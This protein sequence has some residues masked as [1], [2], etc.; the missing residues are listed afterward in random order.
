MFNPFSYRT[1]SF[2]DSSTHQS[3]TSLGPPLTTVGYFGSSPSQSSPRTSGWCR[4]PRLHCSGL[5]LRTWTVDPPGTPGELSLKAPRDPR[6]LYLRPMNWYLYSCHRST[7]LLQPSKDQKI[8]FFRILQYL[9]VQ[10]ISF[11]LLMF[12]SNFFLYLYWVLG[13]W[14]FSFLI[15][16]TSSYWNFIKLNCTFDDQEQQGSDLNP[17]IFDQKRTV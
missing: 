15:K 3:L 2:Y 13:W 5:D 11:K 8:I 9:L 17:E 6:L 10:I 1:F 4:A 16:T 12:S 14:V 7:P